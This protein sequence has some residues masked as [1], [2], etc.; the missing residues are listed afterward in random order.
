MLGLLARRF[1]YWFKTNR[2]TVVLLY[3]LATAFIAISA[4]ISL[5]LV[6]LLLIGQSVD[7]QQIAG[8]T[9]ASMP[10]SIVPTNYSFIISS[11]IAFI[12]TWIATV[13]VLHHSQK[14]WEISDIGLLSASLL[15]PFSPNSNPYS[16]PSC[17][18]PV[19]SALYI[20]CPFTQ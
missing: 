5:F 8:L 4:G 15:C 18:R 20:C 6:P 16:F 10:D 19:D 12:L 13:L 1:F 17:L 14:G 11:V 9:E 7:T 2:N 3:G